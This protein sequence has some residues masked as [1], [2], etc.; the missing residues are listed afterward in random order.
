MTFHRNVPTEVGLVPRTKRI[1]DI[2][3]PIK[4]NLGLPHYIEYPDNKYNLCDKKDD[5]KTSNEK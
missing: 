3:N 5:A 2:Y 1:L 4:H